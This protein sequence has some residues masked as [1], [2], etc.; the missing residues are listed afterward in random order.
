MCLSPFITIHACMHLCIIRANLATDRSLHDRRQR[1]RHGQVAWVVVV[2]RVAVC[3]LAGCLRGICGSSL[4]VEDVEKH[5]LVIR[6]ET[7]CRKASSSSSPMITAIPANNRVSRRPSIPFPFIFDLNIIHDGDIR[8][9]TEPAG[10]WEC[11]NISQRSTKRK[12]PSAR[13]WLFRG[14]DLVVGAGET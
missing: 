1:R 2:A 9:M 10:P 6:R 8:H 3:L 4:G 12:P 11:G 7:A 13:T 14:V 5:Q